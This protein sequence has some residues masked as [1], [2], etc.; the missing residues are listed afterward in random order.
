MHGIT[1]GVALEAMEAGY[2]YRDLDDYWPVYLEHIATL[3]AFGEHT[4]KHDLLG[5]LQRKRYNYRR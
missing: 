2:G 1:N 4:R 3:N 5:R